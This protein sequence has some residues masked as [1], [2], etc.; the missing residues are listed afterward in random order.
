MDHGTD[1]D[2]VLVNPSGRARV[3]Q[4]LATELAAVETPVWAGLMASF[5]RGQGHSVAILD[6]GAEG[7][8]PAGDCG[9]RGRD[10]TAPRRGGRLRPPALRLD[11]GHA[12]RAR[13]RLSALKEL[14]PELPVILVGGHVAALPARTLAEERA[15][16]VADGEGLHTLVDLIGRSRRTP[17]P[18]PRARPLVSRRR[19]CAAHRPRARCVQ[20]LDAEMPGHRLGPA[21]DGP[22]PRPQLALLRRSRARS[23]TP[24]STPRSAARTT[25]ASAASRRRSRAASRWRATRR[26]ST[27]TA[28][29]ARRAC[30]T[31]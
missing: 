27:A 13:A 21:A 29:G 10:A 14:A 19:P 4:S 18:R 6:A 22:L 31:S 15:D 9:P 24:R 20:N 17:R 28:S 8:D 16:F 25:A 26:A 23:P 3:Y 11:A 30:S 1:V 5:V 7:L 2:L 12:G